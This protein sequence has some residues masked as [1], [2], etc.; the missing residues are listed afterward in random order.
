LLQLDAGTA[1]H[2]KDNAKLSVECY[3]DTLQRFHLSQGTLLARVSKR[4]PGQRQEIVTEDALCTIVGTQFALSR[5]EELLGGTT[6]LSVA[7]GCV[8][9]RP[10]TTSTATLAKAVSSGERARI[11]ATSSSIEPIARF[12]ADSLL[13][14]LNRIPMAVAATHKDSVQNFAT[15]RITSEPSGAVVLIQGKPI[16]TTPLLRALAAG[17]TTVTLQKAGFIDWTQNCALNAQQTSALFATLQP[18]QEVP[19][20]ASRSVTQHQQPESKT[21]APAQ[22]PDQQELEKA[23]ALFQQ[24]NEKQALV[25]LKPL[26]GDRTLSTAQRS[27]ALQTALRYCRHSGQCALA[28]ELGERFEA[29]MPQPAQAQA[30]RFELALMLSNTC[31]KDREAISA[32]E[33]YIANYPDG[34][35]IEE[36]YSS[37]ADIHYQH[38]RYE[39][40]AAT[41][42]QL[43]TSRPSS[44]NRAN[45]RY[46]LAHLYDRRLGDLKRAV[47]LYQQV[48]NHGAPSAFA[49]EALFW[50]ADCLYRLKQGAQ[51][52]QAFA[53]YIQRY[54]QG[55]WYSESHQRIRMIQVA[56]GQ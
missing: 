52:K 42:E 53:D 39:R 3:S 4:R 46:R 23:V 16:G 41:Y 47:E 15:V 14:E 9:M 13:G 43:L 1:L 25:L 20:R 10:R 35:F 44:A 5:R 24:G 21:A 11:L 55:A 38:G 34:L 8:T 19:I 31:D 49:E 32:F 56:D 2:L 50:K 51:A 29:S 12:D 40:A 7:E 54:P 22:K 17:P 45:T 36:A 37:I 6:E 28:V 30:V 48:I 33:R 26:I 18:H 27:R